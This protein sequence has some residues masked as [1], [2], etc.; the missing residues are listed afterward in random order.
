M[1]AGRSGLTRCACANSNLRRGAAGY[2]WGT[3]LGPS[4]GMKISP[5]VVTECKG[6]LHK[7]LK[8]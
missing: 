1:H 4:V 3:V 8:V 5:E 7:S 2:T 6:T